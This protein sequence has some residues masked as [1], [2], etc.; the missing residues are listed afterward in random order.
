MT[1]LCMTWTSQFSLDL[2][3]SPQLALAWFDPHFAPLVSVSFVWLRSSD[4]KAL[5]DPNTRPLFPSDR[6]SPKIEAEL[7]SGAHI[8][9]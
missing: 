1:S 6:L 9:W 3:L 5:F 8:Y 4:C 7:H 2:P